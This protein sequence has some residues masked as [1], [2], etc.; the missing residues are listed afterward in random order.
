[1]SSTTAADKTS[2]PPA[3]RRAASPSWTVAPFF[4]AKKVYRVAVLGGTGAGKTCILASLGLHNRDNPVGQSCVRQDRLPRLPQD[5]RP[6]GDLDS[7]PVERLRRDP[8]LAFY[9]ADLW[10]RTAESRLAAGERPDANDV[11]LPPLLAVFAFSDPARG[12]VTVEV[13]DFPGELLRPNTPNRDNYETLRAFVRELDGI[14]ILAA[15]AGN[16]E[17]LQRAFSELTDHTRSGT[18]RGLPVALVFNKW[19][20]R[21]QAG[22]VPADRAREVDALLAESP[23]HKQ[24]WDYFRGIASARTFAASAF[25]RHEGAPGADRPAGTPRPYGLEDPFLWVCAESDRV[26]RER[27]AAQNGQLR[28]W[29]FWRPRASRRVWE[30]AED[31]RNRSHPK[32]ESHREAIAISAR[33][34]SIFKFQSMFCL[35][36]GLTVVGSIG[37]AGWRTYEAGQ[38]HQ[39]EEVWKEALL[40]DGPAHRSLLDEYLKRYSDG[41]HAEECRRLLTEIATQE[42]RDKEDKRLKAEAMKRREAV[43]KVREALGVATAKNSETEVS[44]VSVD[45]HKLA[46]PE[47]GVETSD[48]L[49]SRKKLE[50]EIRMALIAATQDAVTKKHR[51]EWAQKKQD[52]DRSIGDLDLKKVATELRQCAIPLREVDQYREEFGEAVLS[53]TKLKVPLVIERK[54]WDEFIPKLEGGLVDADFIV[55]VPEATRKKL[56]TH[57]K[58]LT[59]AKD[60]S[61]Y[62]EFRNTQTKAN[63]ER[64]LR[65]APLKSMGRTARAFIDWENE[66]PTERKL[67]IQ[68]VVEWGTWAN[69]KPTEVEVEIRREGTDAAFTRV[70]HY[71]VDTKA[72]DKTDPLDTFDFDCKPGN[73]LDVRVSVRRLP[74]TYLFSDPLSG[75]LTIEG[76]TAEELAS[77]HSDKLVMD[78]GSDRGTTVSFIVIKLPAKPPVGDWKEKE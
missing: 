78:T 68:L 53:A 10:L 22:L 40:A 55:L 34:G 16:F 3:G 42:E 63:A 46:A 2:A 5:R 44:K 29:A 70:V 4:A 71:T 62:N 28:W 25:G 14:V 27:M 76:K 21:G 6:N 30:A 19:D 36:L 77:G 17:E 9:R 47:P 35:V 67:A 1:M 12:E 49:E 57:R 65:D 38:L 23:P 20:R 56:E 52:L 8:V 33:A 45:Y 26:T 31:V 13:V 18:L 43:A 41:R 39:E 15:E 74:G 48:D 32:S 64:Y 75:H 60:R 51:K 73:R 11:N 66:R 58:A 37:F 50:T 69:G 7:V 72:N 24:L 54:T 59:E 61:I